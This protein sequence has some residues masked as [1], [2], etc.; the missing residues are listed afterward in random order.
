MDSKTRY[1]CVE[2][3]ALAMI[4][5]VQKIL[6]LHFALHN[7]YIG[8]PEPDVLHPNSSGARGHYS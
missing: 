7:H 5:A 4:I 8:R 6:S 1:S 2:K 3:L